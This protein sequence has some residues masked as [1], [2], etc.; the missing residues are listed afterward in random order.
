MGCSQRRAL[1]A[2][3]AGRGC[4]LITAGRHGGLAPKTAV[5]V[6]L[7]VMGIG[8]LELPDVLA[9]GLDALCLG[10]LVAMGQPLGFGTS[11]VVID[12]VPSPTL[13]PP[14]PSTLDPR[15]SAPPPPPPPP[16]P[17]PPP[18]PPHPH[19]PH[20]PAAPPTIPTLTLT[21]ARR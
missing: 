13:D 15:P 20:P 10:D 8:F 17:P 12:Q 19:K 1:F 7:A 6:G 9:G 18:P 21:L 5:A 4:A 3:P 14:P 16:N 11:Y 2:Q